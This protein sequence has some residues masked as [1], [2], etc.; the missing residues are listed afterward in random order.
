MTDQSATGA[1]TGNPASRRDIGF[2]VGVVGILAILFLPIPP[3]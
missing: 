1:S 3:A 2:A